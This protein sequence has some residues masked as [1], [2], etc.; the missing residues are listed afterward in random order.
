MVKNEGWWI[1][2]YKHALSGIRTHS[3]S[4]QAIKAY[5][6]ESAAIGTGYIRRFVRL[7]SKNVFLT[8][9]AMG[10]WIFSRP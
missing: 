8:T 7:Y 1:D 9:A 3:L 5:A 10:G 2:E 4:I 6:P